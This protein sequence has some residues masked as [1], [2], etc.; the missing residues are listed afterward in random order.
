M[1]RH[2]LLGRWVRLTRGSGKSHSK[3]DHTGRV[4]HIGS[5]ILGE[6]EGSLFEVVIHEDD[7]SLQEVYLYQ[8]K[9]ELL[10]EPKQ[11][12]PELYPPK[13]KRSAHPAAS[14]RP[15]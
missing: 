5:S 6:N 7:G 10:P 4:L 9:L 2:P 3:C 13:M 15:T 8:C 1:D 12:V 11:P 14:K